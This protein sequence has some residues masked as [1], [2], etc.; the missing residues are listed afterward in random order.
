MLTTKTLLLDA[1]FDPQKGW[2]YSPSHVPLKRIIG[3]DGNVNYAVTV[4]DNVIM[5]C[6]Q[7]EL[8]GGEDSDEPANRLVAKVYFTGL[9]ISD[10]LAFLQSNAG[11]SGLPAWGLDGDG[12]L[13]LQT[14]FP[15]SADFPVEWARKQLLVCMALLR[16]ATYDFL[17]AVNQEEPETAAPQHLSSQEDRF[18]WDSAKQVAS[19]AGEFLKAFLR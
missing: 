12:D 10:A 19:V 5:V 8:K 13:T 2:E 1:I 14:A 3:D 16:E 17:K 11:T 18:D 7:S 9:E 4:D 6:E 15:I